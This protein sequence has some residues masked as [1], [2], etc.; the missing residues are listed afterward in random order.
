MK[1]RVH[2]RLDPALLGQLERT[3]RQGKTTKTA[4]LEAALRLYFDPARN[5]PLEER[6]FRRLEWRGNLQVEALMQF[7][8]YWLTHTETLI[9]GDRD[10][11]HARGRRRMDYFIDQVA[12]RLGNRRTLAQESWRWEG[13]KLE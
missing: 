10:F 8:L 7:V 9:E 3:A 11:A 4:L 5:L 12:S 13:P 2:L 6:L 1:P